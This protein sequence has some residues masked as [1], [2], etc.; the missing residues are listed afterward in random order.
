MTSSA[1][2]L[3]HRYG[4]VVFLDLLGTK[5]LVQAEQVRDFANRFSGFVNDEEELIKRFNE[6]L[7]KT[8]DHP[9]K[10]EFR[11]GAF[12][13]TLIMTFSIKYE[14]KNQIEDDPIL[15]RAALSLPYFL[16]YSFAKKLYF[17]GCISI[18]EFYEAP[19]M[20]LGDAIYEAAEYYDKPQWVGISAAPSAKSVL[21]INEK[22]KTGNA[23]D[24]FIRWKLPMKGKIESD[25]WAISWPLLKHYKMLP[26]FQEIALMAFDQIPV[27]CRQ[28]EEY[29]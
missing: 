1:V 6:Y 12:S 7:Q 16:V 2:E 18:G 11:I 26:D 27:N 21:E 3:D 22:C 8:I 29:D 13:D 5:Q 19:R 14:E 23:N 20:L 17:R 25:A 10:P 9:V 28:V 4:C 15:S 24:C